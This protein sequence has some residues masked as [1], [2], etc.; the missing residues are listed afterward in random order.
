MCQRLLVLLLVVC[1]GLSGCASK[2]GPTITKV[3]SYPD[4]Y[5]PIQRLR[6]GEHDTAKGA[7][8]GAALGCG[9]GA[10]LGLASG[11][12]QNAILG[13]LA[14]ATVGGVAGGYYGQRKKESNA[15]VRMAAYLRD[16]EGDI[17][18]LNIETAAART[19]IDC[20]EKRFDQ[21]LAQFKDG[22]ITRTEYDRKYNEIKNGLTEAQ[23]ILGKTVE[24]AKKI[25][26]QY[27]YAFTQERYITPQSTPV[28][29]STKQ[30]TASDTGKQKQPVPRHPANPVQEQYVAYKEK[31]SNAEQTKKE[32]DDFSARMAENIS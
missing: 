7:G 20:Y 17:S 3:E 16:L 29:S 26:E 15:N 11:R 5:A 18:N 13:C 23:T 10:L 19:A 1:L 12:W 9:A 22:Q 30:Q 27:N 6:D 32:A 24:A 21:A 28:P 14:G 2:Y 8:V 4:C 25:D 31:V